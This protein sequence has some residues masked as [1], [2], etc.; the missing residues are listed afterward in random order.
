MHNPDLV[1]V[2]E[3][4]PEVANAALGRTFKRCQPGAAPVQIVSVDGV[5]ASAQRGVWLDVVGDDDRRYRVAFYGTASMWIDPN[6]I[7]EVRCDVVLD[8]LEEVPP[9]R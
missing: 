7:E 6:G 9:D 5:T 3:W 2:P 4:S 1:V 8:G